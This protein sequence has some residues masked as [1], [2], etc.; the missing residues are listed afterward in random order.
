MFILFFCPNFKLQS[1]R[2]LFHAYSSLRFRTGPW[3]QSGLVALKAVRVFSS[4]IP[5]SSDDNVIVT[6]CQ[7]W[8]SESPDFKLV[9]AKLFWATLSDPSSM[10]VTKNGGLLKE[11]LSRN[12]W[13][14]SKIRPQSVEPGNAGRSTSFLPECKTFERRALQETSLKTCLHNQKR[15]AVCRF[16][17]GSKIWASVLAEVSRLFDGHLAF[18]YFVNKFFSAIACTTWRDST[19]SIVFQTMKSPNDWRVDQQCLMRDFGLRLFW[20]QLKLWNVF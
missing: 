20:I 6:S 11:V 1:L 2:K 14:L 10:S 3:F 18:A 8:L 13:R 4:N 9:T 17:F 7:K 19:R 16:C 5:L 12:F 15:I